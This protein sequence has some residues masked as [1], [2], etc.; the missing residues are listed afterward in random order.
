MGNSVGKR[1]AP[2]DGELAIVISNRGG[3]VMLFRLPAAIVLATAFFHCLVSTAETHKY[4]YAAS[5]KTKYC[6]RPKTW[7]EGYYVLCDRAGVVKIDGYPVIS[8]SAAKGRLANATT[9][10]TRSSSDDP[11]GCGPI[12]SILSGCPNPPVLGGGCH[13]PLKSVETPITGSPGKLNVVRTTTSYYIAIGEIEGTIPVPQYKAVVSDSYDFRPLALAY[14]CADAATT[15][16]I[17]ANCTGSCTVAACEVFRKTATCTIKCD[18]APRTGKL[19]I[20]VQST[21]D[22]SGNLLADVFIGTKGKQLNFPEY[23]ANLVVLRNRKQAEVQNL[24]KNPAISLQQIVNA[25]SNQTDLVP[26]VK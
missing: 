20:A 11:C 14:P 3:L 21:K 7:S 18:Q 17:A 24:L 8:S 16:G 23:P 1:L 25:N 13:C 5:G 2:A 6:E 26:F 22:A 9:V 12:P 4:F 15:I 19:V 10:V